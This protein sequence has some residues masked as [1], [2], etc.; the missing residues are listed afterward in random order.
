MGLLLREHFVIKMQAPNCT[1]VISYSQKGV[2]VMHPLIQG[3]NNIYTQTDF[4]IVDPAFM[5]KFLFLIYGK[6]FQMF[7]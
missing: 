6:T 1:A 5:E 7:F 4:G 3:L 2:S